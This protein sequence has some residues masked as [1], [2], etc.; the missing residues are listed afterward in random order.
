MKTNRLRNL[1]FDLRAFAEILRLAW[2]YTLDNEPLQAYKIKRAVQWVAFYA[3][4]LATFI[5]GYAIADAGVYEDGFGIGTGL[6]LLLAGVLG[7][8]EVVRWMR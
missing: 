1:C 4:A 6:S 7:M 3:C 5:G 8:V 2:S